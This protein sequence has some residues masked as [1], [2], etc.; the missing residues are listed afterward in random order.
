M[1]EIS[2]NVDTEKLHNINQIFEDTATIK[3]WVQH[4]IDMIINEM[5]TSS[6][7]SPNAHTAKEMDIILK[8]RIHRAESGKEQIVSNQN[9]IDFI[10]EK[11]GF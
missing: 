1:C 7:L 6:K 5:A 4:Q 8:E 2:I 9:V 11:Y 10:S 3:N